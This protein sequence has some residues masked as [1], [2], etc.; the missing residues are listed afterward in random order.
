MQD[1]PRFSQECL[2]S[3]LYGLGCQ[4]KGKSTTCPSHEDR[5]P[6]ASI[7]CG[8][9]GHW[10][11]YCHVCAKGWDAMDLREMSQG[12]TVKD[13][14][15]EVSGE[16]KPA[17]IR[18]ETPARVFPDLNAIKSSYGGRF[19]DLF[20]YTHPTTGLIELV[21]VRLLGSGTKSNGKPKKDYH[22]LKPVPGGYVFGKPDGLAPIFNRTVIAKADLVVVVEGEPC[23]KAL[24]EI[25]IAGTTSP[26][27]AGKSALADWSP[28]RGKT[29][30][31]WPDFDDAGHSHMKD[32]Q[33][34]L[35]GLGCKVH[36]IKPEGM[37]L[38]KGGDVA[39][40]IERL[41]GSDAIHDVGATIREIIEE[42]APVDASRELY[43][44]YADIFAGKYQAITWPGLE[45]TGALSKALL[46]G[47]ILTICADPGAGKTMM[48]LQM[49]TGWHQAGIPVAALELEDER[50]THMQ[51]IHA[52]IARNSGLA[53]DEWVRANHE[54]TREL[55]HLH[56]EQIASIGACIKAEGEEQM[57]LSEIAEWI[58]SKLA[59]G[60]RIVI[61]DPVTAAV[62]EREPWAADTAF[63]MRVKRAARKHG[64]SI[65]LVTH[66][67][68]AAAKGASLSAMAGGSA[69][70]RFSHSAMWLEKFELSQLRDHL[71]DIVTCNRSIRIT[72][73]RHGRGGGLSIGLLFDPGTLRFSEVA[74]LADT[75]EK[76]V[77]RPTSERSTEAARDRA[78]RISSKP[79]NDEDVF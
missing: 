45:R 9:D 57:K 60:T 65:I 73:A 56:H 31:L 74:A 70:P 13:Q 48:L 20:P 27:G 67:R 46:P 2:E 75:E 79:A 42:A 18:T 29:C 6:S 26:G 17:P 78:K 35:E 47:S 19:L 66:P 59:G 23:V 21:V 34:I 12:R 8:D 63:L 10:R 77:K 33:G 40:V 69:Y 76:K 43:Q 68:G 30:A 7:L 5:T 44:L 54:T 22:Q 72:K 64:A 11:V 25:G 61:V 58:E 32:V 16:R 4:I 38:P 36:W 24:R 39:D 50:N 41:E 71:G 53:D 62:S 37:D 51:R 52:Q 49:L 55:L 14:L 15:K 3:E 1:D 28:L